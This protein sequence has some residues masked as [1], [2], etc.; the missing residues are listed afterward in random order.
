MDQVRL[1][2]NVEIEKSFGAKTDIPLKNSK[3]PEMLLDKHNC[4]MYD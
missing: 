3:L 4:D 2:G 1:E